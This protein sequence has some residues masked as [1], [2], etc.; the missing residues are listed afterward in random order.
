M[1]FRPDAVD[2]FIS[3]FEQKRKLIESFDGCGGVKLLRDI[4]NPYIF[5]TYSTWK[6]EASLENYRQSQLFQTTWAE[7]KTIFAG[8]PEA[9]SVREIHSSSQE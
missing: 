5:F 7:V 6:D 2:G 9:W 3:I 1:T 4:N 8:K